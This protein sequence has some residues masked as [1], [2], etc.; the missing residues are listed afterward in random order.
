MSVIVKVASLGG[1]LGSLRLVA[2]RPDEGLLAMMELAAAE[3][4]MDQEHIR[5]LWGATFL[6]TSNVSEIWRTIGGQVTVT[7]IVIAANSDD[8]IPSLVAS[9]DSEGKGGATPRDDSNDSDGNSGPLV[10]RLPILRT[11]HC[12]L[13][14]GP[15]TPT[16]MKMPIWSGVVH[17][18][19]FVEFAAWYETRLALVDFVRCW[20]SAC[21]HRAEQAVLGDKFE[22]FAEDEL[23]LVTIKT[24]A[25]EVRTLDSVAEQPLR[26]VRGRRSAPSTGVG[27]KGAEDD[28]VVA[29]DKHSARVLPSDRVQGFA[30]VGRLR[31]GPALCYVAPALAVHGA[32]ERPPQAHAGQALPHE[33]IRRR[34]GGARGLDRGAT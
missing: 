34:G 16:A 23:Q 28:K 2:E 12:S 3:L 27:E 21:V 11:T 7:A 14:D 6:S 15:T 8:D 26:V 9:T 20:R 4:R 29:V 10:G 19:C 30:S 18:S 24:A 13:C 5:L 17:R 33:D 31:E 22:K 32:A 25:S 1:E